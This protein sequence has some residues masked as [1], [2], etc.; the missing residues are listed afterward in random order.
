MITTNE[1]IG[2]R[3]G[4]Q[5]F[6]SLSRDQRRAA[7]DGVL[8]RLYAL[9]GY[10]I[11]EYTQGEIDAQV[12]EVA[13]TLEAKWRHLTV[14][15]VWIALQAGVCREYGQDNRLCVSNYIAWLNAY[16]KSPERRE[17][18]IEMGQASR[19]PAPRLSG[20]EI[21]LM[22]ERAC[23]QGALESWENYKKRRDLGIN[24][25]GWA[26]CVCDYL[27]R[28]G[29]INPTAQ[30]LEQVA[31][32]TRKSPKANKSIGRLLDDLFDKGVNAMDYAG[33]RGL[34]ESYYASLLTRGAELTI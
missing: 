28:K 8:K 3:M 9:K 13:K 4:V 17:A 15:E 6:G 27:V 20:G 2:A 22:N 29:K 7:L 31:R 34:L 19:T 5:A 25:D 21:A 10:S 12:E 18:L 24:L 14:G 1:I 11:A 33:K 23:R 32:D 30:T 26:A 16:S